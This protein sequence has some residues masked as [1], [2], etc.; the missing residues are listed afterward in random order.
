MCLADGGWAFFGYEP[1]EQD[2]WEGEGEAIAMVAKPVAGTLAQV[3]Q[4]SVSLPL[5]MAEEIHI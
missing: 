5:S 4:Y 3:A 2:A 1:A